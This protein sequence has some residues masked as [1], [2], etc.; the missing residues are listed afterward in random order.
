MR[1]DA[2][3]DALLSPAGQAIL[4]ELAPSDITA[5]NEIR[6]IDRLR[7]RYAPELVRQAI[8]QTELRRRARSKFSHAGEMLFTTAGLEQASSERMA[9]HHA[10]RYSSFAGVTDL[11]CGLGGDLIGLGGSHHATGVDRDPIHA[12]LARH[13][14][15]VNGVGPRVAVVCADVV[16][17]QFSTRDAVFI[18]PARRV[19]ERRLRGGESEPSLGWCF[20][21]AERVAAMGIKGAPGIATDLV[22]AD[23][24]LEFVSERRE[25]KESAL[26]SPSLRS[27]AR[28]A[29]LLPEGHTIVGREDAAVPVRAP[30]SYL[31]D[32]DP[33]VTRAGLVD[34]LGETMG[35]CWKIDP[36]IGFLSADAPMQ[37]PFGRPLRIEASLG[38]NLK[39]LNEA[40]RALDIG[41]AD[42]RK[43]GS[44]VDVDELHRKLK[45]R[46]SRS[47]TVVLTR[48][49]DQ[50]WAFVCTDV[51]P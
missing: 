44:P 37:T 1:S 20:A 17:V 33:A 28:R 32:V 51:A 42:I 46:G 21:L 15:H 13:N 24:E 40:L 34:E 43:R 35:E 50:P 16:D 45:L 7:T 36:R 4:A 18:D 23:W 29:T 48:V 27:A 30:G 10:D 2:W 14:A 3:I 31:L 49:A 22:P 47:A 8:A 41:R 6:T 9:R 12:R 19:D 11:C 25:L 5:A 38:W 39:R 26:W